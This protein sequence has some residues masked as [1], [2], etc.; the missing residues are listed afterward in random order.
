MTHDDKNIGGDWLAMGEH[1]RSQPTS[2]LNIDGLRIE[3]ARRTR[4]MWLLLVAEMLGLG[5][6]GVT[7]AEFI[8][9]EHGIGLKEWVV[10]AMLAI[11]LCFAGWTIW[12][13]RRLWRDFGLDAAA[14]VDL[15][16]ARAHNALRYW[17]VNSVVACALW[18]VVV[19]MLSA[20]QFAITGAPHGRSGWVAVAINLP[21]VLAA[22]ALEHWRARKL[23]ARIQVLRSMQDELRQ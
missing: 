16:I 12:S 22:L 11:G 6:A 21:L 18:L 4:R 10:L 2:A 7:A 14:M 9:R 13:R 3:A 15:E 19:V 8:L 17:R 1:W 20:Q 5:V 23:H